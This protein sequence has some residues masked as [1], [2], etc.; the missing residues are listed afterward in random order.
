M[1]EQSNFLLRYVE[2]ELSMTLLSSNEK[3]FVWSQKYRP[4]TVE[5]CILPEQ[6]KK[7][8]LA[9]V[10]KGK[11]DG[12]IQ[13]MLFSGPA[14]VGKTT[15]ALALC[16]ELNCDSLMINGSLDCGIDTLRT[17]IKNFAST[18]SLSGGRKVVILD[19]AD[20]VPMGSQSALRGVIEE[21]S[22]NARFILTCNFKHKIL[23]PIWSRC[24]VIDFKIPDP[25]KK[26]IAATLHKR[27]IEI[28]KKEGVTYQ[29]KIVAQ[30]IIKHF[31]DFRRILNELQ[32]YSSGGE[33]D[34]GILSVI[35]ETRIKDL[36]GYL[37]GKD[38]K[39]MRKWVAENID[40]DQAT[41]FRAIYDNAIEYMKPASVPQS[42]LI[43]AQ[44]TIIP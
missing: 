14:G 13:N 15:V 25:E 28:L 43:I 5:E 33:I 24:S 27:V 10:K 38:F 20:F 26:L 32:K 4:M 1:M 18:V 3:E 19:E 6:L 41:I 7:D 44:Y 17:T 9:I 35:S 2:R 39:N 42:V 30:L 8:F 11:K 12:N 23:Q 31:P 40:T 37:K 29:E 36:M 21:F 34:A 16:N 22:K